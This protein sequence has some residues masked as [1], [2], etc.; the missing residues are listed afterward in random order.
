MNNEM[1][2]RIM[3]RDMARRRDRD[4]TMNDSIWWQRLHLI[5]N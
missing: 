5:L 1:M 4:M 2:K 3:M